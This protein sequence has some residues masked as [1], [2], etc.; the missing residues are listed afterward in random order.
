M[1]GRLLSEPWWSSPGWRERRAASRHALPSTSSPTPRCTTRARAAAAR[2]AARRAGR[3]R[4]P[5]RRGLRRRAARLPAGRRAGR[6]RRPAAHRAERPAVDLLIEGDRL[7]AR[8]AS[9]ADARA[10]R[11]TSTRPP[12]LVHTSGTTSAPK[13]IRLTYGNWLWSALGSAVALGVDPR[14]ALALHAAAE[15]RRRPVDPAALRDLRDDR[16]RPRALRDRP[17]ARTRSA[18]ATARR[19]SRS[20]P[21]RSPRLLDAGL[22]R[23]ARAALG[24]AR[25]RAAAARAAASAPPTPASPSRRPTA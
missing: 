19:S 16:D 25:R 22:A 12:I 7:P 3:P 24:A 10:T 5:A 4:A 15:P 18:A 9:A 2:P 20:S 21:R 1:G 6:A 8:R 11:T 23:P 17:R 14:R 13:P